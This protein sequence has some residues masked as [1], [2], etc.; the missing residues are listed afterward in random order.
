MATSVTTTTSTEYC[1]EET[2]T[3]VLDYSN[4]R[5]VLSVCTD[6]TIGE[7]IM[8]E[9]AIW[10]YVVVRSVY[11][12][13]GEPLQLLVDL[14]KTHPLRISQDLMDMYKD[15]L[16]ASTEHVKKISVVG[17]VFQCS[18]LRFL[19]LIIPTYQERIHFF[20]DFQKAKTWLKW[21]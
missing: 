6:R 17:D 20:L 1:F 7:E 8:R 12:T 11:E 19:S 5:L 14:H 13:R 16:R 18:L 4:G 15:M 9:E 21:A 2:G 3:K 10:I